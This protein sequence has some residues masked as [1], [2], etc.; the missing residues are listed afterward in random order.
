MFP[1]LLNKKS[2][3]STVAILKNL[4]SLVGD[5][6]FNAAVAEL[7][8]SSGGAGEVAKKPRKQNNVDPEK[9]AKRKLDMGALQNF[10]K[11]ERLKQPDGT[12]YK[13]IQKAAGERWKTMDAAARDVYKVVETDRT[14]TVV[15]AVPKS[16]K[17][18]PKVSAKKA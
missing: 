8:G 4:R 17:L 7:S 12:P 10:I 1:V 18:A 16:P 6:T 2:K 15:E 13:E 14:V 11:S 3:M 5:E 9:S